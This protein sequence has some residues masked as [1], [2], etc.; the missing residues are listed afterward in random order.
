MQMSAISLGH[1]G[2]LHFSRDHWT[3][4]HLPTPIGPVDVQVDVGIDIPAHSV[5]HVT[6]TIDRIAQ[7]HSDAQAYLRQH[8]PDDFARAQPLR[9]PSLLF[10][11]DDS[12]G[13]FTMFYSGSHEDDQMIYGVE[14]KEFKPFD[15]TIGD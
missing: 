4:G 1:Y 7:I 3:S 12:V 10:H 15:L 5:D 9:A 13:A 14:F 8:A 6:T 11:P 2:L